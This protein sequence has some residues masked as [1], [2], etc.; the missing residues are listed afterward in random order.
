MAT[1]TTEIHEA[2]SEIVKTKADEIVARHFRQMEA[3]RR[4]AIEWMREKHPIYG[5]QGRID[6]YEKQ[7]PPLSNERASQLSSQ[8][9]R[10][11]RELSTCGTTDEIKGFKKAFR[12]LSSGAGECLGSVTE[13]Y[14]NAVRTRL[15]PTADAQECNAA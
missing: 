2:I 8:I 1:I 4:N 13:A 5:T 6:N 9:G 12:A 3:A 11:L 14:L 7:Y 10:L 15:T